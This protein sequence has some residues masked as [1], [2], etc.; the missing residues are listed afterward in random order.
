[1]TVAASHCGHQRG[2]RNWSA[3]RAE[4]MEGNPRR[5]SVPVCEKL[6]TG[7]QIHL[8]AG[9]QPYA[10]WQSH[11]GVAPNQEFEY[12]RMAPSKLKPQSG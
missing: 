6:E 11:T 1:M 8:P 2:L 5:K 3:L 4:W 9:Q 7:P 10:Y 12:V